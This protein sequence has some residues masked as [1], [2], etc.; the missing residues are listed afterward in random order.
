MQKDSFKRCKS[1]QDTIKN[2]IPQLNFSR[3][4]HFSLVR[5]TSLLSPGTQSYVKHVNLWIINAFSPSKVEK[6]AC[7][8][9]NGCD[10]E[11][12][13][14]HFSVKKCKTACNWVNAAGM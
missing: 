6:I 4:P 13:L 9:G 11:V 2:P 1:P 10:P 14:L 12:H 3:V 5:E 8:N 7:S